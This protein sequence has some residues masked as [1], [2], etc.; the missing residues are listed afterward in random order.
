MTEGN[1]NMYGDVRSIGTDMRL[2][3]SS[4]LFEGDRGMRMEGMGSRS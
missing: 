3:L 2:K 4:S 1:Q